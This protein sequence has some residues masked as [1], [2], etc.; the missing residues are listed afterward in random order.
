MIRVSLNIASQLGV[1]SV[2]WR[3]VRGPKSASSQK[4]L[5]GLH[6]SS[7]MFNNMPKILMQTIPFIRLEWAL[8]SGG[9]HSALLSLT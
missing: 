7:L 1:D 8:E 4:F 5:V 3:T 6:E 2:F 9:I